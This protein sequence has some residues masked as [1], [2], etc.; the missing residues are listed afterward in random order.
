MTSSEI[1]QI[2]L[3]NQKISHQK[4]LSAGDIVKW[5]G[6]IQA[7]DFSMAKW[8][9]GVRSAGLTATMVDS[10]FD[11]GEV[12]RIHV[13][14]PTWHL[15]SADDIYWMLRLTAPKILTSLRSRHKQLGLSESVIS[16]AKDIIGKTLTEWKS[17]TR[18]ELGKEFLKSDIR[19]D[20]NRLSHILFRGELDELIC[21]G[22]TAENKLTYSLL[23]ERVPQKK[24]LSREESL[25]MLAG[26]YFTSRAPATIQDFAWWSNLT[27]K[28]VR[29]ATESI[30][31]D[32]VSETIGSGKYLI[33]RS[34]TYPVPQNNNVYILPAY[35]EFLLSYKDRSSSLS[36]I[37]NKKAV[38]DNGIFYPLIVAEGQIKGVWK[39]SFQRNRVIIKT[40][41]FQPA[42]GSDLNLINKC[43]ALFGQFLEKEVE[44]R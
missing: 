37:Y 13:L 4:Y 21:S 43:A 9:V 28:D 10:S 19:I 16:K 17:L 3:V 6:A 35:D 32:F 36:A 24:Y 39:R 1:S 20:G 33:P 23:H 15:V 14:R 31:S 22:P 27:L 2:R 30:K 41:F 44:I 26:R 8:A 34:F 7:Q 5:M 11:K 40:T 25:A 29:T 38:S 18:E 12:L 42:S